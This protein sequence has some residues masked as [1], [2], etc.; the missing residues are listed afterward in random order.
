MIRTV[1]GPDSAVSPSAGPTTEISA[2]AD[3]LA[4]VVAAKSW[5]AASSW[6]GVSSWGRGPASLTPRDPAPR[7]PLGVRL[8]VLDGD[9]PV[10]LAPD[11]QDRNG[12]AGQPVEQ[13]GVGHARPA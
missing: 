9:H 5:T 7:D 12:D 2:I 11:H 6:S 1:A 10:G 8:A 4:A 13:P 3:Q